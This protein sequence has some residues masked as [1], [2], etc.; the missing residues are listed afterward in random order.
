MKENVGRI[1]AIFSEKNCL[2]LYL[3]SLSNFLTKKSVSEAC[4]FVVSTF[5]RVQAQA[6]HD[7]QRDR[8]RVRERKKDKL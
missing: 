4:F 7:Q 2:E 8:D 3:N 6:I 1:N 5:P